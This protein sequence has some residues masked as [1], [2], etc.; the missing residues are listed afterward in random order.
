M[1]ATPSL[2][3]ARRIGNRAV[4]GGPSAEAQASWCIDQYRSCL[5]EKNRI[6]KELRDRLEESKRIASESEAQIVRMLDEA[7]WSEQP[8]SHSTGDYVIRRKTRRRR[9]KAKVTL[10][11]ALQQAWRD[12]AMTEEAWYADE[13]KRI[14]LAR[15]MHARMV[16][17]SSEAAIAMSGVIAR[18]TNL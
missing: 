12:I 2:A 14:A 9:Q 17:T 5:E 18:Q 8:V 1:A 10:K 11:E 4:R 6:A 7:D 13:H 3:A 16:T 15:Q